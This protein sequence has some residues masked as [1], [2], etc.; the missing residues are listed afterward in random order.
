MD[1]FKLYLAGKIVNVNEGKMKDLAMEID[2]VASNMRKDRMMKP[3]ADKFKKDAMKSM[4]VRKSLEKVLPDYVAGK[5]LDKVMKEAVNEMHCKDCGCQYG[6]I[7]PNCDCPNDGSNPEGKHWVSGTNE[8]MNFN[9]MKLINK[10]AKKGSPKVKSALKAPSRVDN[11]DKNKNEGLWDNIRKKKARIAKGSGEKMRSKGDKGAPTPDQIKRA[12]EGLEEVNE[13]NYRKEYDNYQGRPEQIANRS[14]R[15]SARRI[16]GDKA[17]KGMDVGHKDNNPLNNDPKNLQMEDPSENRREP[18]TREVEEKAT[19][20]RMRS[21]HK[22]YDFDQD[23][24]IIKG[25]ISPKARSM[26]KKMVKDV[27]P[28]VK[29][30]K[31][32]RSKFPGMK[33]GAI[34]DLLKKEGLPQALK[35][36]D[37]ARRKEYNAFQKARRK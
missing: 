9:R 19:D 18:R 20:K 35:A 21:W 10:I 23:R 34:S 22:D 7:D 6:N 30:T 15:N 33:M 37:S 13:R 12:S 28:M 25:F 24:D 26:A 4:N 1:T 8:A 2:R 17:I 29:A 11:K 36:K 5:T 14:S 16:M 31:M 27:V 32:I 3:F